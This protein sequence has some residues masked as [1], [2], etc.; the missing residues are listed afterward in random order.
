VPSG[1]GF[2]APKAARAAGRWWR[3]RSWL[4][5]LGRRRA[6]TMAQEPLIREQMDGIR[7]RHRGA[8]DHGKVLDGR[9][10]WMVRVWFMTADR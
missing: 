4:M 5:L 2:S 3:R 1:L 7:S 10:L 8:K 6:K 9:D